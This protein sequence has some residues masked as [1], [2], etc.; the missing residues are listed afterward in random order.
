[1]MILIYDHHIFIVLATGHLAQWQYVYTTIDTE[2]LYAECPSIVKSSFLNFLA[3]YNK[4]CYCCKIS[5]NFGQEN[6]F[7]PSSNVLEPML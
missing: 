4:I 2:C 1:M 6:V 5:Y 7:L 3:F